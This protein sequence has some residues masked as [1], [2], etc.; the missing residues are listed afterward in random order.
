MYLAAGVDCTGASPPAPRARTADRRPEADR[1]RVA[2]GAPTQEEVTIEHRMS[3]EPG[4][5]NFDLGTLPQTFGRVVWPAAPRIDREITVRG[6]EQVIAQPGTR[7][8]VNGNIERI[9]I[10]ADDVEVRGSRNDRVE[11]VVVERG[12]HRVRIANGRF[13]AIELHVPAQHVPPP[14]VWRPDWMVGD[15]TIDDVD[16]EAADTAFLIRGRRIA[17]LRSRVRAYRYSVWC[18]DT[19]AFQSEDIIIAGN[20][21]ESAGPES[22]VRLVSVRRAIV[23]DNVLVNTTKHD[24]RVHGRSDYVV[25]ARN[26]LRNTGVMVGSMEGDNIGTVWVLDNLIYHKVPSLFEVDPSRV[27]HLVARGNRVF[28]DRWDCFVCERRIPSWD[29]ADNVVRPYRQPSE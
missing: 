22:T 27:R 21:M 11:H 15:I 17:I 26:R 20:H 19:D 1:G 3:E 10:R 7:V 6:G 28:S 14:P 25:F 13:G 5:P 4:A 23:V 8:I 29:V 12:R 2:S 16:V 9:V 24:F 18:G